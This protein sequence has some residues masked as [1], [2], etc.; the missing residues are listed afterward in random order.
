MEK[1]FLEYNS[2]FKSEIFNS[3]YGAVAWALVGYLHMK[4]KNLMNET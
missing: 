1:T 3:S 4:T 2:S